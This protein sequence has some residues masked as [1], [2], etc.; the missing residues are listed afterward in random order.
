MG[1]RQSIGVVMMENKLPLFLVRKNN[2]PFTY[3][4]EFGSGELYE[5]VSNYHIVLQERSKSIDELIRNMEGKI[6]EVQDDQERKKLINLKRDIFNL[7]PR[8]VNSVDKC[9]EVL[10]RYRLLDDAKAVKAVYV[11]SRKLKEELEEI[12]EHTRLKERSHLHDTFV[13]EDSLKN[14]LKFIQSTI[15]EKARSYFNTPIEKHGVKQRKLDNTLL[16]VLTRATHKTSPF[17]TLTKVG[18]GEFTDEIEDASLLREGEQYTITN[19]NVAF[20]L[21]AFEKVLLRPSVIPKMKFRFNETLTILEDRYYWTTLADQ[22]QKRKKIFRTADTLM[23][24]KYN[25][26]LGSLYE[27]LKS[28]EPFTYEKLEHIFLQVGLDKTKALQYTISL[29]KNDFIQPTRALREQSNETIPNFLSHLEELEVIEEDEVIKSVYQN[30]TEIQLQ[31]DKFDRLSVKDSFISYQKI[32][33]LFREISVHLELPELDEKLLIYQDFLTM[34]KRYEKQSDWQEVDQSLQTFQHLS[35]I[36][37][38]VLRLQYILGKFVVNKYGNK[39]VSFQD[40]EQ[41]DVIEVILNAILENAGHLWGSQFSE[42]ELTD[43]VEEIKQLDAAKNKFIQFLKE[44]AT[45]RDREDIV[46]TTEYVQELLQPLSHML[47]G[48]V[49]SNSFFVQANPDGKVVLNDMYG[50]YLA[51]FLR[52][53]YNMKDVLENPKLEKYISETIHSRNVVDIYKSY[54][55]NANVRPAITRNSVNVPNSRIA[56]SEHFDRIISWEDLEIQYNENSKKV[57]V[58]AKGEQV[59]ILFLGSLMTRLIP[60]ISAMLHALSAN[61]VL[62]R[63]IGSI[64]MDDFMLNMKDDFIV[65]HFPRIMLNDNLVLSRRC[66]VVS[67]EIFTEYSDVELDAFIHFHRF[68]EEQKIPTRL[69]LQSLKGQA[70]EEEN[71]EKL[72]GVFDKPQYIDFTSP[73]L[74]NLFKKEVENTPYFLLTEI[75]PDFEGSEKKY[76]DEYLMEF[77]SKGVK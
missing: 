54:G 17:S 37:D 9:E 12:Y 3:T 64:L 14:A 57:D 65:Q 77:T 2:I 49:Q 28:E 50:G 35:V 25:Q 7:R 36:F 75:F 71:A 4:L 34:E 51:Y 40:N 72:E 62:F 55:F 41:E 38:A 56:D 26:L 42:T 70:S 74:W 68:L 11:H 63:D 61:G 22:P 31:L 20:L 27:T 44:K 43:D 24:I 19:I 10:A 16:K 30:L 39:K 33:R 1:W 73:L 59:N 52:F 53:F 8:L 45:T 6:K 13:R 60:S 48:Y 47:S 23:K 15:M 21:R 58:F 18:I 66:W 29:I 5:K 46:I 69:F 76:V 32:V 67:T